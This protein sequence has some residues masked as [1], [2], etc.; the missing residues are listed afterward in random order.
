M[1]INIDKLNEAQLIELNHRIIERL[2]YLRQLHTS[3]QM[4]RFKLGERVAFQPEGMQPVVGMVTRLNRKTVTVITDDGQHWN[5]S[6]R[7]LHK[8]NAEDPGKAKNKIV[9]VK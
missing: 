3:E 7:Y 4:L 9:R 1:E 5:V 8:V 6:P 2:R